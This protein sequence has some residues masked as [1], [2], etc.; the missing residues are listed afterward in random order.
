MS[1]R[2]QDSLAKAT[3]R[4][5]SDVANKLISML[6]HEA[7]R[8]ICNHFGISVGDACYGESVHTTFANACCYCA[9]TLESDRAVVEHPEGMNRFRA[10]L[11]IPGNALISCK[12][13]NNEKRRD[14]QKPSLTLASTGWES[15]LSHDSQRC[16]PDCKSCLYWSNKIPDTPER[17]DHLGKAM[18]RIADFQLGYS[19][20]AKAGLELKPALLARLN[21]LYRECQDFAT[22]RITAST[23]SIFEK[24]DWGASKDPKGLRS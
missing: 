5:K 12:K 21:S 24:F 13:C 4:A 10:G 9:Q 16:P 14:D 15:F 18:R 1:V 8:K 23:E 7:S 11:H 6:L 3:G 2:I 22:T 20:F 19:E 17:V